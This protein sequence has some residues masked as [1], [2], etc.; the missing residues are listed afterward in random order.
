MLVEGQ[1]L[2][3]QIFL[4]AEAVG[5]EVGGVERGMGVAQRMVESVCGKMAGVNSGA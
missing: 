4:H 3:G 5:G 2:G 1:E